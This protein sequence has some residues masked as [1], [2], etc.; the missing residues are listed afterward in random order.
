MQQDMHTTAGALPRPV[1][2]RRIACLVATLVAAA[3]LA[4]TGV[5]PAGAAGTSAAGDAESSFFHLLNQSRASAGLPPLQADPALAATS[6]TWSANMSAQNRLYHDPN[7][8]SIV[9]SVEPR[10]QSGAENVG[11]GYSTPTL[12]KAF[13]E[14]PAHRASMMSNRFNRVG[15]GVVYNGTKIWVTV[16]FVEGP[17]LTAAAATPSP[18]P[19]PAGVRTVL[20]GDFNG[21]GYGDVLVYGPGTEADELWFGLSGWVMRKVPVSVRGQYQP[22]AGDFDGDGRTEILWYAPGTAGDSLWKWNGSGWS[23]SPRT[24]NGFYTARAGDF[25]GDG[26]DDVLWYAPGVAPDFR[27]Y[28]NGNGTFTSSPVTVSGAF[29]PVVGDFDGNG[30]DDVLWYGHGAA[31]DVVWYST[32]QRGTQRSARTTIGGSH[33][34]FAG[35]FDGNGSDDVFFYTP[36]TTADAIWFNGPEGWATRRTTEAVNGRYVPGVAELDVNGFDDIVW[37][38]PDGGAANDP[39]WWGVS[40]AVNEQGRILGTIV[41]G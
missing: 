4:T 16:R 38:S 34:A 41:P 19:T 15:I 37:Y 23:S 6:R 22:V 29:I 40:T 17:A 8:L 20:T 33:W 9:A 2:V 21:D 14:S 18:A 11:V 3:V 25:D 1:V 27:W 5:V 35:D 31:P 30:G 24:I 32:R 10:W 13:M 28:G 7:L 26:V 36:G 12:H 39:L